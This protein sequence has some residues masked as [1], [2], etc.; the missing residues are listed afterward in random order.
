MARITNERDWFQ[1]TFGFRETW[2]QAQ[3]CFSVQDG[4]L[5]SS[6]ND[7]TFRCGHFEF[8]AVKDIRDRVLDRVPLPTNNQPTTVRHIAV[9]DVLDLHAQ[10]PNAVFQAASQFNALEFIYAGAK[11]ED[12]ITGYVHD[13]TQGPAC[14]LA[15]PAGTVLRNYFGFDG[16]PQTRYRQLNGLADLE[17]SI[18]NQSS[19][20]FE[21]YNGYTFATRQSLRSF[22]SHLDTFYP[23][24][25]RDNLSDQIKIGIQSDVGVQFTSRF[26]PVPAESDIRVTQCYTSAVSCYATNG[27][28]RSEFPESSDWQPFAQLALNAAYEGTLWASVLNAHKTGNKTVFLTL[29]GGGAFRNQ[30]EWIAEAIARAVKL[31][32]RYGL[33]VVVCHFKDVNETFAEHLEALLA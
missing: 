13:H 5:Y 4:W 17:Q 10:Q 2:S 19:R 15:C 25:Q 24:S 27:I 14:A 21:V 32:S 23:N 6:A 8:I 12:G 18:S 26:V 28:P 11:P 31:T 22:K 33:D 30:L 20:C 16:Q 3:E 7:S 29:V 1:A 9:A